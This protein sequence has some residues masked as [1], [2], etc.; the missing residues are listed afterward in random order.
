MM[1]LKAAGPCAAAVSWTFLVLYV[2]FKGFRG[3]PFF[4][5]SLLVFCS[6]GAGLDVNNVG[7]AG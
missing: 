4:Y 5:Q 1:R 3:T 2:L 7:S 6:H